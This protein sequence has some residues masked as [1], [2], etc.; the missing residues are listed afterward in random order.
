MLRKFLLHGLP[1]LL[2]FALYVLWLAASG[3]KAAASGWRAAPWAWLAAGGLIL[4]I[5]SFIAV[6]LFSGHEAGGTYV[7]PRY[8][9]G[10][11][12]PAETR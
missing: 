12:A 9:D 8:L 4:V 11:V 10:K 1:F 3:R 5:L 7:P 6:A 2:P